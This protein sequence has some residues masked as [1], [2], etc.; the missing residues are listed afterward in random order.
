[1]YLCHFCHPVLLCHLKKNVLP[2]F[3]HITLGNNARKIRKFLILFFRI[4]LSSQIH[5]NLLFNLYFLLFF[6]FLIKLIFFIFSKNGETVC[7]E[8]CPRASNFSLFLLFVFWRFFT[9]TGRVREMRE[10]RLA[11]L[12]REDNHEALESRDQVM[13]EISENLRIHAIS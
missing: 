1:M 8:L 7:F 9:E 3:A 6:S 11:R 12:W 2:S 5:K 10:R 13:E 4:S